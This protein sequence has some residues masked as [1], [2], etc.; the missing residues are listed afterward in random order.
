VILPLLNGMRHLDRIAERFGRGAVAGGLCKV[1]AD[2]D[3]AGRIVQMTGQQDLVFGELDRRSSER[4]RAIEA[5]MSGAGFTAR[6]SPWI[7]SEMWDKWL[8]LVWLGTAT[9]LMRGTIGEIDAV[10]GGRALLRAVLAE[11]VGAIAT[12]GIAPSAAAVEEIRELLESG[13]RRLASSMYRDLGKG[14]RVE[15][16]EILGDLV[17]RAHRAGFAVPLIEAAHVHLGIHAAR[18]AAGA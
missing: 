11:A 7:E 17:E 18:V 6:L 15:A 9:C 14:A 4:M 12:V 2:L 16:D 8:L 5:F 13:N 10:A 3:P 1:V